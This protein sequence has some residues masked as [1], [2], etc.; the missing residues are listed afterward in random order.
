[1]RRVQVIP[2]P[3]FRLYDALVAEEARLARKQKGTFRRRGPKRKNS[4]QWF[5]V[6]YPGQLTLKREAEEVVEIRLRSKQG[7]EWQLLGAIVGFIDRIFGPKVRAIN[8][9]YR[10]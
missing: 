4:A 2:R 6:R 9:E 3:G 5:H 7:A 1:M 8:I 10:S